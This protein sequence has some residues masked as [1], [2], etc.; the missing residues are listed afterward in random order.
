MVKQQVESQMCVYAVATEPVQALTLPHRL[1]A[2]SATCRSSASRLRPR[3]TSRGTWLGQR[4]AHSTH[5]PPFPHSRR[6]TLAPLRRMNERKAGLKA[7]LEAELAAAQDD[8]ELTSLRDRF[9]AE[10]RALEHQV[11]HEVHTFS[12]TIDLAYNFLAK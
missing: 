1:A 11:D 2:R 7:K 9:S 4:C 10:E 3:T 5:T 6:L 12:A 8:D